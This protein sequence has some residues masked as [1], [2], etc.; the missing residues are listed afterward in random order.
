MN[1]FD[2]IRAK[3]H[4]KPTDSPWA[5]ILSNLCDE[6]SESDE[7]NVIQTRLNFDEPDEDQLKL[8]KVSKQTKTDVTAVN[9]LGSRMLLPS[10]VKIGND[11]AKSIKTGKSTNDKGPNVVPNVSFLASLSG[12]KCKLLSIFAKNGAHIIFLM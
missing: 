11:K 10:K 8:K 6:E 3:Y 5:K 12:E 7:E 2:N 9:Q 1:T 4:K